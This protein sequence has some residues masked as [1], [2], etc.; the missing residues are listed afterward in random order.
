M[1]I[2]IETGMITPPFGMNVFT[3]KSSL[4]GIK[5]CENTT[6]NDIFAGSTPFLIAIIVVDLLCVFVPSL[7][8]YL[9]NHMQLDFQFH[10]RICEL[11]GCTDTTLGMLESLWNK[12]SS[13]KS[14]YFQLNGCAENTIEKHY[15]IA[16]CLIRRDTEGVQL[17]I[18]DHLREVV[19]SVSTSAVLH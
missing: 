9:P 16:D 1:I 4:Y 5:G 17:A 10:K 11:S 18:A 2:A 14:L 8:T 3:V 7:V 12:S 6:V 13:F 15:I 19:N